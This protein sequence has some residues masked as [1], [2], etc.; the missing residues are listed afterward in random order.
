M[1]GLRDGLELYTDISEDDASVLGIL[2]KERDGVVSFQGMR[3]TLRIHQEK[4][5]R[6]LRRLEKSGLVERVGDGYTLSMKARQIIGEKRTPDNYNKIVNMTLEEI[7][8][9][10]AGVTSLRGRWAGDFRWLGYKVDGEGHILEWV[11][12]IRPV[13]VRLNLHGNRLT[14]ETDAKTPDDK[15]HALKGAF[16]IIRKAYELALN[17]IADDNLRAMWLSPASRFIWM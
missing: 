3:R 1:S 7:G 6:I 13:S 14:I 15:Q 16:A 10:L 17:N 9:L 5:S 2:Q 8:P 11:S 12:S 4:L